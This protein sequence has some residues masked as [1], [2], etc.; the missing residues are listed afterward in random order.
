ML[1]FL[2]DQ[3]QIG[4]SKQNSDNDIKQDQNIEKTQEQKYLTVANQENR[5]RKTTILLAVLFIIGMIFLWFMIR[6][7]SPQA[8]SAKTVE[9]EET[10]I[11]TAIARL[12]GVKSEMF[13]KMDEIVKKFYE[14]SDVLQVQVSELVKNPFKLELFLIDMKANSDAGQEGDEMDAEL[15]WQRQIKQKAE[16]LKLLSIMQS[17][18]DEMVPSSN[19]EPNYCC[20]INND[21]LHEGDLTEG[22]RIL[23]IG[24]DFVKIEWD[25]EEDSGHSKVQIILKLSE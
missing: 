20:M 5:A 14:F 22:F 12:T 11:E 3:G 4:K 23:Q 15:L 18:R 17:E 8:A 10:Q 19:S 16:Q 24:N 7:S 1:S 9:K 13:S 25:C 6:K 2:R 21:I